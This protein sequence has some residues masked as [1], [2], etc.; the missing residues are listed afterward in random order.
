MDEILAWLRQW[1]ALINAGDFD[2]AKPLFSDDVIGYGS[3]APVMAG[4]DDLIERQWT[5]VWPRIRDFAFDYDSLHIFADEAMRVV[6]AAT[7]WQSLGLRPD[8]SWYERRG[9]ATLVF[10]REGQGYLCVHSHFSMEPG[11]P[12]V[13]G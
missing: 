1:Q 13:D 11:I 4:R 9:R 3:L 10:R 2:A 5:S 6:S 7:L 8:G 12:P